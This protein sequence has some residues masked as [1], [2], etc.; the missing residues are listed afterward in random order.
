MHLYII[1]LFK[2]LQLEN[3]MQAF[4]L[5]YIST[6]IE[7]CI[8][9][10]TSTKASRVK[11]FRLFVI[12]VFHNAICLLFQYVKLAKIDQ[13]RAAYTEGRKLESKD[14]HYILI[15]GCIICTVPSLYI[16]AK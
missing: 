16:R 6:R 4:L 5:R 11:G 14:C 1:F 15:V 3:L 7:I 13:Q 10:H 8:H 9:I 2:K 12:C